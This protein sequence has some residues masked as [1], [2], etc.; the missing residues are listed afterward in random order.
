MQLP[1]VF[2]GVSEVVTETLGTPAVLT[3][4]SAAPVTIN[5]IIRH[6][7][8]EVF[9]EESNGALRTSDIMLRAMWS[10]IETVSEGDTI[11]QG[12]VTY[13]ISERAVHTSGGMAEAPLSVA[14][15]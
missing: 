4:G 15:P 13:T 7:S 14:A 5:A 12:G 11:A 6:L 2:D 8:D 9:G 1:G 10:D 3:I